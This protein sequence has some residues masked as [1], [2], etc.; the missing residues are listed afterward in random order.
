MRKFKSV[1][2][3]ILAVLVLTSTL[4][5]CSSEYSIENLPNVISIRFVNIDTENQTATLLC[6][7][8]DSEREAHKYVNKEDG[9]YFLVFNRDDAYS[10]YTFL[11]ESGVKIDDWREFDIPI[12]QEIMDKASSTNNIGGP[13]I[14]FMIH[15]IRK[16]N[17]LK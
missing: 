14:Y 15:R 17:K 1:L 7:G 6:K 4:I 11:Q 9:Y 3:S 12:N 13:L 5:S 10:V 2:A 16:D 8:H